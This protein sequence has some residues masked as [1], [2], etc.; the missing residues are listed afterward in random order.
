M[1]VSD[2]GDVNDSKE[3]RQVCQGVLSKESRVFVRPSHL[4]LS[5]F[6]G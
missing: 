2:E 6:E 4:L 1:E 5:Y 3:V